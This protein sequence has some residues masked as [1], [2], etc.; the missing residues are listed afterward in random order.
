MSP[1]HMSHRRRIE[2]CLAGEKLD[3]SPVAL[4]RHFPVDDQDPH[5]L[6]EATLEFQSLYDFDLVKVT[7]ASSFCIKD[8]GVEDRW[9]GNPEGTRD[10]TRRAVHRP[11]D[12][13]RLRPL[14]LAE[15]HREDRERVQDGHGPS[16]LGASAGELGTGR[17]GAASP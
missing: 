7:P 1:E 10:Y 5:R 13:A 9:T 6:A 2:A 16:S 3:R 8:W 4:W 15:R 11:E 17:R 14:G 12:W